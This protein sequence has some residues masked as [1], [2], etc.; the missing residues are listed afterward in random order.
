MTV[1]LEDVSCLWALPTR[2]VP[3]TGVADG[4]W[5]AL[6]DQCLGIGAATD[7]MKSKKRSGRDEDPVYSASGYAINLSRLRNRF[8]K[9][10]DGP[11][12]PTQQ[13]VHQY[14]RAYILDLFG[15]LIFTDSSGDSVPAMYLQFIMDLDAPV[16]YNW[17]GAALALL[18]MNLCR[19]VTRSAKPAK[20]IWGP[21]VLLQHWAWSRLPCGRPRAVNDWTPDW[22]LP[23]RES[24]PAFGTKWCCLHDFDHPHGTAGVDYFR[25]QLQDLREGMVTWEPYKARYRDLPLRVHQDHDFWLVR[26]PLIHFWIVEHH[27]PDRV[28]R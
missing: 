20:T 5:D 24:C 4:P 9:M 8:K 14:T 12:E 15:S 1:T 22:G 26:V 28:R 6:V 2:G 21:V 13:Q 3:V 27:Y 17:G 19:A 11:N 10:P 18:Y 25:S 23:D 7:L 16:Q